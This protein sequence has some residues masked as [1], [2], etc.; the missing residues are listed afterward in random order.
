MHNSVEKGTPASDR[1]Q[2]CKLP[3][4]EKRFLDFFQSRS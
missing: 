2:L 3:S 4:I 1:D